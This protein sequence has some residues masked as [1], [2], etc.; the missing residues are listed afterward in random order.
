M[1]KQDLSTGL[2]LFKV[3]DHYC[4]VDYHEVPIDEQSF[5]IPG[6]EGLLFTAMALSSKAP[7]YSPHRHDPHPGDNIGVFIEDKRSGKRLFYAP[8]LGEIEP[9]LK[10]YMEKADCLLVDGTFWQWNRGGL[11]RRGWPSKWGIYRN[12]APA[13]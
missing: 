13:E 10:P 4:K 2:P 11:T 9:H 7:P 12:L 8:G 1:A 6:L 5:A 3:L